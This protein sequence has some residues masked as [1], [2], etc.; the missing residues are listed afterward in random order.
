[1]QDQSN[2]PRPHFNHLGNWLL[3]AGVIILA[4][5]PV[6]LLRGAEFNGADAQAEEAI[7]ELQPDYQAWFEPIFEPPSGEVETLLFTAQAAIGAGIIGYTMGWYR[8]KRSNAD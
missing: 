8:A 1:M 2:Q 3:V 6:F 5:A 4:A 7:A